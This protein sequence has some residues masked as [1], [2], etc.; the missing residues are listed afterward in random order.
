MVGPRGCACYRSNR[1][2]GPNVPSLSNHGCESPRKAENIVKRIVKWHGCNPKSIRLTPV[3]HNTFLG[4]SLA[5]PPPLLVSS[6]RD[7]CAPLV[8][9]NR[10]GEGKFLRTTLLQK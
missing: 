2:R 10:R 6:N 7:L 4:Q 3:A 5:Q 8:W 9:L 1:A